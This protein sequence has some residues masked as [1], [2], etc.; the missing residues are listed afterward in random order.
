MKRTLLLLTFAC[1]SLLTR[2]QDADAQK[3]WMDYMTPG[4]MHKMMAM[5]DG[6]WDTDITLWMAPGTEPMKQIGSCTCKMILDGR[7]QESRQ[8][9]SFGG[10]KFDGIGLTGF[11]N[12]KKVFQST[13]MDNMGTGIMVLE[14]KWDDATRTIHYS[15]KSVDPSN[16]NELIIRQVHKWVDDNTQKMEMYMMMDGK[17]F[18]NMEITMTRKKK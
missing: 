5:G 12:A 8:S 15:G 11:D 16:G 14:G 18:K 6:D 1:A 7:F 4:P 2:A 3:A 9:G 13:W 10:M 17:E